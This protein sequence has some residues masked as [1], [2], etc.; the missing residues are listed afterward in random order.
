M[1]LLPGYL[2]SE[3]YLANSE[4]SILTA[5]FTAPQEMRFCMTCI[6]SKMSEPALNRDA[7]HAS[8]EIVDKKINSKK[9]VWLL[10]TSLHDFET[11]SPG[12]K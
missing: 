5:K 8:H 12:Q 9:E 7:L 4:Q 2:Q 3:T 11:V 6:A 10:H 1:A